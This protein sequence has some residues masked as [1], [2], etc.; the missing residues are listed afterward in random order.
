MLNVVEQNIPD[1]TLVRGRIQ[2][3]EQN[4]DQAENTLNIS[5]VKG[6]PRF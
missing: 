4:K 3:Q 1:I 6:C 5:N 2:K